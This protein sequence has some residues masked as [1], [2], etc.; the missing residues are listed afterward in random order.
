MATQVLSGPRGGLSAC[1]V[2]AYDNAKNKTP[3][4]RELDAKYKQ[5]RYTTC[6]I[7]DKDLVLYTT[8]YGDRLIILPNE[9][10]QGMP[11][12]EKKLPRP[13]ARGPIEDLF[14]AIRGGSP[15]VASFSYA[16]PFTEFILTGQLAMFAGPGK[17]LEWDAAATKCTNFP[18]VNQYVQRSYRK[19]WEA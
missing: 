17:K 3:L 13:T 6:Y 10:K 16:A 15:P 18:D 14:Q 8:G 7:T 9:K 5:D 19:G 2:F 11:V 4:L 12:P 1:K